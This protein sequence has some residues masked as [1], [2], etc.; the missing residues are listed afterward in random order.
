MC[1]TD[2]DKFWPDFGQSTED[3][4][5]LI[6][7]ER[8]VFHHL[9]KSKAILFSF[10]AYVNFASEYSKEELGALI[11]EVM[12]WPTELA[13][14]KGRDRIIHL[15]KEEYIR[16]QEKSKARGPNRT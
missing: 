1:I 2:P 11:Q 16:A 15:L 6:R 12:D 5:L 7:R 9:P 3:T 13:K 8:Q 4:I 14:Y 10:N